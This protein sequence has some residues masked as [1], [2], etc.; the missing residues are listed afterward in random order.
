MKLTFI[1]WAALLIGSA[2]NLLS[3]FIGGFFGLVVIS[4]LADESEKFQLIE[5]IVFLLFL[6]NIAAIVVAWFRTRLGGFLIT[7]SAILNIFLF[8]GEWMGDSNRWIFKIPLLFVG[9]L[10]LFYVYYN[11]RLSNKEKP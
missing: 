6:L 2:I 1:R 4:R 9:L 11:Q 3:L 7:L 5:W 8:T 10:L